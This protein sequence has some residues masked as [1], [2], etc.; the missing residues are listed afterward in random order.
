MN[1][2]LAWVSKLGIVKWP[3]LIAS[4]ITIL[5]V[6]GVF[7]S[8]ELISL[9]A[10][11]HS[12]GDKSASSDIAVIGITQQCIERIG[13]LPW[14]RSTYAEII[15]YL[16]EARAKV[17]CFD[18]FFP[19][20]SEQQED[21]KLVEATQKAGNVIY[22]VFSP[23]ALEHYKKEPLYRVD[24][25]RENMKAL[26]EAAAGIGHIN[27]PPDRDGRIRRVPVALESKGR[28]VY[29]LGLETVIHYWG[30]D[31]TAII[32]E[33]NRLKLG[34]RN[35][36]L[37]SEGDLLINFHGQEKELDFYPFHKVL[38]GELPKENFEDK[39]VLIGQSAHGL[40][41]ADLLSTPQGEKYGV[42]VQS[43]IIDNLLNSDFLVRQGLISFLVTIILLSLLSGM[44]FFRFSLRKSII[45]FLIS[46]A[47][48]ILGAIYLFNRIGFIL[49][50]VPCLTTLAA[51]FGLS[52][53]LN[54]KRSRQQVMQKDFELSSLFRTSR[55]SAEDL[56][57]DR[58]PQIMVDTIGETVGV[59]ALSLYLRDDTTRSL[60]LKA[61]YSL[62]NL[63]KH[64]ISRIAEIA[65]RLVQDRGE[66]FLTRDLT[67]DPRFKKLG[68]GVSSFLSSPLIVGG[69]IKGILNFYNKRA[70]GAS[71]K[72]Y[73]T[74]ED[75]RL[76]SAFSHQI[77]V[78]LENG[79]L[80]QDIEIKNERLIEAMGELKEAQEELVKQGKLSA[81]GRMASMIIH[82]IKNPIA[83]VRLY[84]E[85]LAENQVAREERQE[86]S[87]VI[88]R[89]IDRVVEMA[90]E[91]LDYTKGKTSL[92]PQM[93][94]VESLFEEIVTLLRKDF[95]KMGINLVTDISFRGSVKI[96]K[97]KM[98]RVLLN[99]A[100]N[101]AEA[102]EGKGTV[103]ILSRKEDGYVEFRVLDDGPGVPTEIKN[104]L[105]EP[106]IT[107]GKKQGT[108]LGLAIVKKIVEDHGGKIS[109]ES[110]LAR[111]TSFVIELPH[112]M[113]QKEGK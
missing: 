111:G 78:I 42:V 48:V 36:P 43:V 83:T 14:P 112:E 97:E 11:F 9:D 96:D 105:F 12:R 21:L 110:K 27:V 100:R 60:S 54:L 25:L 93:V 76:I 31:K 92:R 75:L 50:L 69:Q 29:Q 19:V 13:K 53:T 49:E 68:F 73:F 6:L 64:E 95:K 22:A 44:L 28:I 104:K 39:I 52:L 8:L 38:E 3:I 32:L 82:D 41:N 55:I 61:E 81:V 46:L 10:R 102:M 33:K 90:Q 72:H 65:N 56:G 66:A 103:R 109:V 18:I 67:R 85:L 40:P 101:A 17:I 91:V 34:G 4:G 77:A 26:S 107:H 45:S 16:A 20:R 30:I 71:R 86:Y 7:E 5:F 51:N 37:T 74:K 57:M 98:I 35:L 47:S 108:G 106:F 1:K 79:R 89:Q 113:A 94:S 2:K 15:N 99:L 70:S 87:Q 62:N 24:S 58:L 63:S 88:L 59:E 23:I 84:A 80:L